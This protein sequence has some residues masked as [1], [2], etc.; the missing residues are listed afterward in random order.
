MALDLEAQTVVFN[1]S[2][3]SSTGKLG[4]KCLVGICLPPNWSGTNQITFQV[5]PDGISYY[6]LYDQSGTQVKI[7]TTAAGTF[8]AISNINQRAAVNIVQLVT[9]MTSQ[10]C[11][12]ALLTRLCG[13]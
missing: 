13:F 11:N 12:V 6:P 9:V 5:S 8:Y 4:T 10:T 2:L 3:I 7:A 1:N